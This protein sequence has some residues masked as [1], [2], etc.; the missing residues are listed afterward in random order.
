[1]PPSNPLSLA[2]GSV[3][4]IK[5]YSSR[6]HAPKNKYAYILGNQGP[7][8]VLAFLVSTQPIHRGTGLDKEVVVIPRLATSIFSQESYIQCFHVVERLD[9][10]DLNAAHSRGEIEY[11]GRLRTTYLYKVK[12]VV[13][14]SDV[15]S[16]QEIMDCLAIL[17][18]DEQDE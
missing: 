16:Q 2:A 3:L 18:P 8:V 17:P 13:R 9:A 6:G 10:N 15:L 14:N 11:K 4:Y 1:M 5:G 7:A 12:E